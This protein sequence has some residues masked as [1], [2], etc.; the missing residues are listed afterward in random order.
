MVLFHERVAEI[1]QD[2]PVLQYA[3][4]VLIEAAALEELR[5]IARRVFVRF[6]EYG[7]KANYDKVKRVST[8]I[9]F[10]G[11]EIS[12]GPWSHENFLR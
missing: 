11:C 6:D 9:Q 8:E 3:D 7:I 1:V 5:S 10:L 4:N 2:I 12:N